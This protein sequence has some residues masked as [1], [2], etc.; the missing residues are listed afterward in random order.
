MIS[1]KDLFTEDNNL[2]PL[3]HSQ[4]IDDLEAL[5][6]EQLDIKNKRDFMPRIRVCADCGAPLQDQT[7]DDMPFR[8][9]RDPLCEECR[10]S[11]LT[12]KG[13]DNL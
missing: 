11:Y 10:V 2:K 3:G 9:L 4:E 6:V 5:T 1:N 7:P 12:A 8:G 13:V